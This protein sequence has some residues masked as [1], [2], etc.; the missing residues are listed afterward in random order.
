MRLSRFEYVRPS[1]LNQACALLDEGKDAVSVVAGG[2]D[3][4]VR[5]KQRVSSP[6]LVVDIKD[7]DELRGISEDDGEITIGAAVTLGEIHRSLLIQESAAPL[8]ETPPLT[9]LP[10]HKRSGLFQ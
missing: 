1:T 2:T 8:A 4:F 5:M 10:T 3:L 9:W 7:I 6:D